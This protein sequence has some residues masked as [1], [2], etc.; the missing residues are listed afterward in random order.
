MF[1]SNNKETMGSSQ[2]NAKKIVP[3]PPPPSLDEKIGHLEKRKKYLE[4]NI[5]THTDKAKECVC[6]N[7]RLGA[8]RY[9]TT[10]KRFQNELQKIH[11][12]L[13]KLEELKY[14]QE[15]T[16][17]NRDVL[18]ALDNG[19]RVLQQNTMNIETAE[20][21]VDNAEEAIQNAQELSDVFM[22]SNPY[23][24]NVDKE[25]EE[26]FKEAP[27]LVVPKMPDIPKNIV[28]S[29]MEAELEALERTP[30]TA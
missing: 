26:M 15:N 14:A 1:G 22:R 28:G 10:I 20:N 13:S 25:L 8:K 6:Q 18:R 19:T 11:M 9:L 24:V 3:I 16:H 27:V 2:S 29:G 30:V 4:T 21:I 17:I 7:D 23:D 5:R 12:M